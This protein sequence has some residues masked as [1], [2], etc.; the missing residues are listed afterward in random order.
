MTCTGAGGVINGSAN[1]VNVLGPLTKQELAK[2]FTKH[3]IRDLTKVK[4]AKIY[5]W[6]LEGAIQHKSKDRF[7]YKAKRG[8]VTLEKCGG[9]VRG[10]MKAMKA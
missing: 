9:A 7:R 2:N 1:L 3:Q 10:A 8:P 4:Y 6:V 5:A